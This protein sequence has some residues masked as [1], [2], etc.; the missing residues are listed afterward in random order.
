VCHVRR[1][2]HVRA[3][4]RRAFHV[5][6]LC[7]STSSCV[8]PITCLF[9]DFTPSMAASRPRKR[10]RNLGS[11]VSG[12]ADE[13]IFGVAQTFATDDLPATDAAPPASSLRVTTSAILLDRAPL[14]LPVV[15]ELQPLTTDWD[16]DTTTAAAE[17][18]SGVAVVPKTRDKRRE[19]SVRS[20]CIRLRFADVL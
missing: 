19:N 17:L 10:R 9:V 15:S 3:R 16:L 5:R 20:P 12:L 4:V 8:P 14:A 13:D 11:Q 18:L 6:A 7:L 1:V 2:L